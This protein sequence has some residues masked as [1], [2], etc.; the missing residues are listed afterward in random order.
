[1]NSHNS[2]ALI[3]IWGIIFLNR[4]RDSDVS[5]FLLESIR[6]RFFNNKISFD[7]FFFTFKILKSFFFV[8]QTKISKGMIPV[9]FQIYICINLNLQN[10][11]YF[12]KL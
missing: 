11:K 3:Q 10:T 5:H 12:K 4:T 2:Q 6:R 9:V 7:M 1:M 8:T